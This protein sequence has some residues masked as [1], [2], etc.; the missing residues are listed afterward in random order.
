MP[1]SHWTMPNTTKVRRDGKHHSP[2]FPS[3]YSRLHLLYRT[4]GCSSFKCVNRSSLASDA[5]KLLFLF[6][7]IVSV[8]YF[9]FMFMVP[10]ESVWFL[11]RLIYGHQRPKIHQ[12]KW[13]GKR[14]QNLDLWSLGRIWSL[15]LFPPIALKVTS[16]FLWFLIKEFSVNLTQ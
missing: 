11:L 5:Y 8:S 3:I 7:E 14:S 16:P 2:W 10:A 13:L 4:A 9:L 12:T 15:S 1:F 6:P